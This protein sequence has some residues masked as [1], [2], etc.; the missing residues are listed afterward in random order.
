MDKAARNFQQRLLFKLWPRY[1]SVN[2]CQIAC[3]SFFYSPVSCFSSFYTFLLP[4]SNQEIHLPNMDNKNVIYFRF[5]FSCPY[6]FVSSCFSFSFFFF[7]G[8][9]LLKLYNFKEFP[10][11]AFSK[12]FY[13]LFLGVFFSF[14]LLCRVEVRAEGFYI[15]YQSLLHI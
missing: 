15:L 12:M 13:L 4:S 8:G 10:N 6:T 5:T 3:Y 2:L 14:L 7:G 1:P 9:V 11:V